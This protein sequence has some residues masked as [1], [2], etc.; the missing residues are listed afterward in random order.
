MRYLIDTNILLFLK[1]DGD[2][3][4]SDVWEMLED[5]E[6]SILI[7][8]ESVREIATLLKNGKVRTNDWNTFS[9]IK[10]TLE[11]YNIEIRYV[12]EAHLKTLF[13]L[14]PAPGHSDPAD[15]M[16]ISQA[17]AE[18]V[19]L[20]SS[21]T[22]FPLYEKQGLKFIFNRRNAARRKTVKAIKN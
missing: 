8:S 22:K 16:I 17:I 5:C 12:A 4:D 15:L 21:D 19:H 1:T 13:K 7:S 10:T 3:L 11:K 20:I 14:D 9:D 2:E 18:G 6:N